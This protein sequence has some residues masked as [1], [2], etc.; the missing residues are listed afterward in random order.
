MRIKVRGPD[1]VQ[2]NLKQQ[3]PRTEDA[4]ERALFREGEEMMRKSKRIT[5]VDTGNLRATGHVQLPERIGREVVIR[6]G[7]GGPAAPY[8][9]YVHEGTHLQFTVG[10]AKY[11][12]DPVKQARRGFTK[13][14]ADRMAGD[15]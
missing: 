1:I 3:V 10:Q 12:Q 14:I 8:A 15:R 4:L 11:L 7:F 13:R 5:P 6:L 2:R 9:V